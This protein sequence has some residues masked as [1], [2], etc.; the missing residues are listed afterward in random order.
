MLI[1]MQTTNCVRFL[2]LTG[3]ALFLLSGCA[4]AVRVSP[5]TPTIYF[6]E[7]IPFRVAVVIPEDLKNYE[8]TYSAVIEKQTFDCGQALS[9]ATIQTMEKIFVAVEE[10]TDIKKSTLTWDRALWLQN[11]EFKILRPTWSK[12][13]RVLIVIKYKVTNTNNVKTFSSEVTVERDA[14][15]L[16]Q[17]GFSTL[18]LNDSTYRSD[19]DPTSSDV[20]AQTIFV[21]VGPGPETWG[22]KLVENG[23]EDVMLQMVSEITKAHEEGRLQIVNRP[24]AL[25]RDR[26]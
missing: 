23:V 5:G 25:R 2:I 11:K 18:A 16:L 9:S 22:R 13:A 4:T 19:T 7:K 26:I 8:C 1:T 20:V 3:I 12:S 21:P 17:K 15:A 6:K 14:Y 24:D 10:V